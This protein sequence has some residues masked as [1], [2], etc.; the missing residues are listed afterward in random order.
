M[1]DNF[2]QICLSIHMMIF[3]CQVNTILP[4]DSGNHTHCLPT[5]MAVAANFSIPPEEQK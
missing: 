3:C 2:V 1:F 4:H 5:L